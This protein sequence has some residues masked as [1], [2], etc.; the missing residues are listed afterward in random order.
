MEFVDS[1]H[2]GRGECTRLYWIVKHRSCMTSNSDACM[3]A[4]DAFIDAYQDITST[5]DITR[6]ALKDLRVLKIIRCAIT[7]CSAGMGIMPVRLGLGIA[8]ICGFLAGCASGPPPLA[9]GAQ[10]AEISFQVS[11]DSVHTTGKN[12]YIRTYPDFSCK[13]SRLIATR[14]LT[15]GPIEK[16]GPYAFEANQPLIFEVWF[17]ESRFAQNRFCA[18][19]ASF[20]PQ[21]E[22][23]Y[24]VS[25]R[26][27][28][29]VA[30]CGMDIR[31]TGSEHDAEVVA[32]F[33]ER[34]CF[35]KMK[36]GQPDYVQWQIHVMPIP[37]GK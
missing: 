19:R 3:R 36:N 2:M 12:I 11:N 25:F 34:A 16:F 35:Q 22:K 8:A 4:H 6:Q 18:V 5:V 23:H 7:I 29:Q 37:G 27:V 28:G 1:L 30:H 21:P 32:K 10:S 33:P 24:D 26:S 13:E 20:V 9:A 14:T 15:A 17:G 31:E